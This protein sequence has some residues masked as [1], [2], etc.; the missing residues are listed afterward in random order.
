MSLTA[1]DSENGSL[2]LASILPNKLFSHR[3]CLNAYSYREWEE[4]VATPA[5]KAAG[6][7]PSDWRTEDGDKFGPLIRA[8]T[9]TK[10]GTA[11]EYF[12]P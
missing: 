8:V 11:R 4:H 9:L 3:D 1:L 2:C 7:T 6:Y 10:G 5:L 12:Y